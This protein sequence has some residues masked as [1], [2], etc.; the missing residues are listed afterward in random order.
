MTRW[1]RFDRYNPY[2]SPQDS[3]LKR[4]STGWWNVVHLTWLDSLEWRC[5]NMLEQS[6]KIMPRRAL[7]WRLSTSNYQMTCN[8]K[9]LW[10]PNKNLKILPTNNPSSGLMCV[11]LYAYSLWFTVLAWSLLL[12][13][14]KVLSSNK[15]PHRVPEAARFQGTWGV[16]SRPLLISIKRWNLYTHKWP[17]FQLL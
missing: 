8:P 11:F 1:F 17:F 5:S 13:G 10:S 9:C 3:S 4:P 15:I 6:C 2:K 7:I 12:V 14:S 16:G